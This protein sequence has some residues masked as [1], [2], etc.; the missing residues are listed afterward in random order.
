MTY[1][2]H[3]RSRKGNIQAIPRRAEHCC[4]L[5]SAINNYPYNY[6]IV[7]R[8]DLYSITIYGVAMI[9]IINDCPYGQR[10]FTF[11]GNSAITA[12]PSAPG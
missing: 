4:N 2:N 12:L 3:A 6:A 9:C 7:H 8:Y 10:Y 11:R 1:A 5:H